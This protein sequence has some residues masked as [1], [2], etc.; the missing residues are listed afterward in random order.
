MTTTFEQRPVEFADLQAMKLGIGSGRRPCDGLACVICG[1][2]IPDTAY[3]QFPEHPNSQR[4]LW[5]HLPTV[6]AR[7][8]KQLGGTNDRVV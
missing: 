4:A 2:G 5:D 1:E 6:C 8:N 7:H 3:F